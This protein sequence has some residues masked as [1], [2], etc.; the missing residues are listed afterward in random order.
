MRHAWLGSREDG[1][2]GRRL[3]NRRERPLVWRPLVWIGGFS[4][5]VYLIHAPLIQLLWQY[6]VHPL[7]WSGLPAFFALL[8]LGLP[9]IVAASWLFWYGCERPFL[10]TRTPRVHSVARL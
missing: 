10:N 8:L 2:C 3:A 7:G 5:S 4:Y 1:A 9:L 6:G